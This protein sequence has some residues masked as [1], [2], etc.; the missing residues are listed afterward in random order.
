MSRLYLLVTVMASSETGFAPRSTI[1]VMNEQDRTRRLAEIN[2][3]ARRAFFEGAAEE[4]TRA[5]GRSPTSEELDRL[6]RPYPGDLDGQEV[7]PSA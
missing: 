4:W 2:E 3:G 7:P 5:N 1:L 6:L